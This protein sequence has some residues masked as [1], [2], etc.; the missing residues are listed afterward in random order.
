MNYKTYSRKQA[1]VIY[2]AWKDGKIE[3]AKEDA[4]KLYDY[5]GEIEVYNTNAMKIVETIAYAIRNAV[6]AIFADNYKA[7]QV[8]INNFVAA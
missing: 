3:M 8:S 2:R 7:A 1:G 4:N 6:D 5:V